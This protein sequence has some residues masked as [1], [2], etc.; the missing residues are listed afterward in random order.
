MG[1]YIVKRVLLMLFVLLVIT[2]ICCVLVRMLPPAE[3][4][5]NDPHT[6]VIEMRREAAGYNK[7]YLVQFW[8]AHTALSHALR[9]RSCRSGTPQA[10]ICTSV[11]SNISY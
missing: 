8:I 6:K 11:S 2:L 5:L 3:L 1:K 4:P 7:P 10:A 9:G